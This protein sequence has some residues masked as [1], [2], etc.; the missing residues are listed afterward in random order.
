MQGLSSTERLKSLNLFSIKGRLLHSDLTK[1]WKTLCCELPGFD[2]SVLFQRSLEERI[3]GH[4]FKLIMSRC[5]TDV[6]RKFFDDCSIGVWNGLPRMVVESG[7]L[8]SFKSSL[9]KFLGNSLY[10]H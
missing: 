4:S 7:S 6:K 5:N 8:S 10:Q 2:F 1:Y 9:A 3:R